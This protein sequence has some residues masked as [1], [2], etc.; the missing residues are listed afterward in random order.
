VPGGKFTRLFDPLPTIYMDRYKVEAS[1]SRSV[2][3]LDRFEVPMLRRGARPWLA[4]LLVA[5]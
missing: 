4:E 5:T 3:G 2:W 1:D